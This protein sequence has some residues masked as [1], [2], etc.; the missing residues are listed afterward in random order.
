MEN[1]RLWYDSIEIDSEG[2]N[3]EKIEPHENFSEPERNFSTNETWG[4]FWKLWEINIQILFY[5]IFSSVCGRT[6]IAWVR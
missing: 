6:M 3:I 2:F 1:F 4:T 5:D